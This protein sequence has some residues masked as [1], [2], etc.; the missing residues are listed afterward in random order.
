MSVVKKSVSLDDK[1]A[2][3]IESAATEDGMT[4]STWLSGAAERQLLIRDGL[5]GVVEWE[6]EEGA[7]TPDERAAGE[8][9]LDRLLARTHVGQDDPANGTIAS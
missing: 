2:A 3:R 7:L 8:A 5:R 9:L 1:V 6:A 4:F